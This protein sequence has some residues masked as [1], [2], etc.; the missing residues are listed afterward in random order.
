MCVQGLCRVGGASGPCGNVD[1]KIDSNPNADNDNDGF[2]NSMDNCEDLA[3]PD[4]ANEDRDSFGDVCDPCPIDASPAADTDSDHDGVGNG[5]DPFP[6]EP[7]RIT[8]FEG[9]T[10]APTSNPVLLP[11]ASS[12]V[13]QAGKASLTNPGLNG[14]GAMTWQMPI[15]PGELVVT[16]FNI[17]QPSSTPPVGAGVTTLFDAGQGAGIVCWMGRETSGEGLELYKRGVTGSQVFSSYTWTAGSPGATSLLRNSDAYQCTD[18]QARMVMMNYP[19]PLGSPRAGI[20]SM[21]AGVTFEY[22][23]VVTRAP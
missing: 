13:Y 14:V 7:S 3:N 6:N 2:K 17:N 21:A 10:S 5:C 4:Q 20:F 23:M 18:H 19:P 15:T 8:V 16:A 11:A 9:F 12:W 22:V 1:A